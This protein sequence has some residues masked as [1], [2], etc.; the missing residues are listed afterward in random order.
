MNRNRPIVCYPVHP[1]I[2]QITIQTPLATYLDSNLLIAEFDI[3]V[4]SLYHGALVEVQTG[5]E[6]SLRGVAASPNLTYQPMKNPEMLP[7]L[8]CIK[9]KKRN[10]D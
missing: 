3:V 10:P 5:V 4:L 9:S 7:Q 8:N 6:K 2:P 1:L